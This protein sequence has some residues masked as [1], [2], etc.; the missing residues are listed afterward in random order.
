MLSLIWTLICGSFIGWLAGVIMGQPGTTL[1]NI[2]VGIAGSALGHFL[3]RC[4][5]FYAT[6]GL[7]AFLVSVIG[8]CVLLVIVN[9]LSRR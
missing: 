4:I 2:V 8:A 1:R 6:G 3:F 7:A 9:W 5:G